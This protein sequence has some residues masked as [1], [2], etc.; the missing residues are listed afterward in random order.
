[1]N[2]VLQYLLGAALAS[3]GYYLLGHLGRKA[4]DR[5]FNERRL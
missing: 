2:D 1:M 5:A 4:W 3:A